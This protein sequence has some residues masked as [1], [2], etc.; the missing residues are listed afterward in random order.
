MGT[1]V[2]SWTT[3]AVG[4]RAGLRSLSAGSPGGPGRLVRRVG[5]LGWRAW[6]PPEP[7]CEMDA[8]CSS[9]RVTG[10]PSVAASGLLGVFTVPGF[11]G[12]PVISIIYYSDRFRCAF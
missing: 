6:L 7:G 3:G 1:A 10:A 9:R 5:I 8:T 4:T 11:L 2:G 12:W